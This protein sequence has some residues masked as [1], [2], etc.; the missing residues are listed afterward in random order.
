MGPMG[1]MSRI[2]LT[3]RTACALLCLAL[4]AAGCGD[5]DGTGPEPLEGLSIYGVDD[6]NNLILFGSESPGTA[7]RQVEISGLQ[8]GE[9]IV[10]IDFRPATNQLY[11]VGS[12]SLIYVVDS[13]TGAATPVSGTAF[14]PALNGA[15]F[16]IDFNPVPDRIRV[17][18]EA[19]QDLRLN[20]L[21][22][23]VAAVDTALAYAAGDANAGADPNVVGTAYTNSVNPPPASTTLFAIDSDLDILV[24][25]SSPNSGRLTTVGS[26]GVNTNDFVGFDIAGSNG[27][28]YAALATSGNRSGLYTINLTTGS[29]TLVGNIAGE[30]LLGITVAP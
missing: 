21:T 18:S 15:S 4:V 12:S 24:T 16:G 6:D 14:S 3:A 5:D 19:E 29:A 10:G 13:L 22:G 26:L 25:L 23:A 27:T 11:A 17:H 8:A 1:L 30:P 9:T 28:A 7:S 2:V 20:Q